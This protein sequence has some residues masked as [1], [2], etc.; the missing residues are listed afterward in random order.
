MSFPLNYLLALFNTLI[1]F[2]EHLDWGAKVQN[3]V[4]ESSR[5]PVVY[6][7]RPL[8]PESDE[9]CGTTFNFRDN[10]FFCRN[11]FFFSSNLDW[12]KL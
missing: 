5:F 9:N 12:I 3:L 1:L 11:F 8:R 2:T 7:I 6:R 4:L 10:Y